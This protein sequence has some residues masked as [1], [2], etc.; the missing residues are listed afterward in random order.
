MICE[1]FLRQMIPYILAHILKTGMNIGIGLSKHANALFPHESVPNL[2]GLHGF[3]FAVLRTVEFD[4]QPRLGNVEIR[5]V[6]SDDLLPMH[7]K[8]D[9]LQKVIP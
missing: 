7:G 6:P 1:A 3:L 9:R 8:G 2:I 5:D 4:Y